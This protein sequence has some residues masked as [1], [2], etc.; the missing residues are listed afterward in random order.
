MHMIW[1]DHPGDK[2]IAFT[3]KMLEGL[4]DDLGVGRFP[5]GATAVA[6]IKLSLK[7]DPPLDII[8]LLYQAFHYG[9]GERIGHPEGNALIYPRSIEMGQIPTVIP[10]PGAPVFNRL[11]ARFT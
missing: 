10:P 2:A 8:F 9:L 3:I 6:R 11:L 5:E 4:H 7:H 1:H